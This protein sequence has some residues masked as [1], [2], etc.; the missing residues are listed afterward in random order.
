MFLFLEIVAWFF[1]AN[2]YCFQCFHLY[3]MPQRPSDNST[4]NYQRHSQRILFSSQLWQIPPCQLISVHQG[5][6]DWIF[7]SFLLPAFVLGC[8]VSSKPQQSAG[9][10]DKQLPILSQKLAKMFLES[11][12]EIEPGHSRCPLTEN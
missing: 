2:L 7:L 4:L 8:W 6:V 11:T 1:Q 12:R 9:S 5:C 10:E 3:G